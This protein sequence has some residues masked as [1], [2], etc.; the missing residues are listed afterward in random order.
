MSQP[1]GQPLGAPGFHSA[2]LMTQPVQPPPTMGIPQIPI[3]PLQ[4]MQPMQP[5][6]N[7]P[8]HLAQPVQQPIQPQPLVNQPA[9]PYNVPAAPNYVQDPR[10]E[11]LVRDV[12]IIQEE[13]QKMGLER[14]QSPNPNTQIP[15]PP[16]PGP[17]LMAPIPQYHPVMPMQPMQPI[18]PMYPPGSAFVPVPYRT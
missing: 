15:P 10:V 9:Q 17:P 18:Q 4:P 11:H 13:V 8:M 3:Q 7:Q 14:S 2:P 1:T 6:T 5:Q 12:K 16:S